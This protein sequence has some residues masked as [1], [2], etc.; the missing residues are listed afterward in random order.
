[1]GTKCNYK[2]PYKRVAEEDLMTEGKIGD[3][4]MEIG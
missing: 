1:M 4:M 2:G 3:M